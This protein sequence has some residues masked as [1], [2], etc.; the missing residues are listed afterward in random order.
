LPFSRTRFRSPGAPGTGALPA[1]NPVHPAIVSQALVFLLGSG[2][3]RRSALKAE[4]ED[5]SNGQDDRMDRMK[6][7][8]KPGAQI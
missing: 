5:E 3:F 4:T 8:F 7:E 1:S 6:A 2:L